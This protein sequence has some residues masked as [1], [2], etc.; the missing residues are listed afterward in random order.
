MNREDM[1]E[2]GLQAHQNVDITSHFEGETRKLQN[3]I[4]VEYPIPRQ[5]AAMY[6]P[7]AN[8]LVP[9]NSTEPLSNCPTFKS[10]VITVMARTCPTAAD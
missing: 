2:Q 10:T 5:C 7:E 6:Y 1:A 3:Y 9:I 4:V 8:V